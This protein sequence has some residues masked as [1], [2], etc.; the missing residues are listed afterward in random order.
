MVRKFT[1]DSCDEIDYFTISAMTWTHL[2][3]AVVELIE[4]YDGEANLGATPEPKLTDWKE[5]Y[6]MLKSDTPITKVPCK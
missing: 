1:G 6:E 2:Q 5:T 3:H 4:K